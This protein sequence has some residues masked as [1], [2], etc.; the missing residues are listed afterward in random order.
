MD[1]HPLQYQLMIL[2]YLGIACTYVPY[3]LVWPPLTSITAWHRC[4]IDWHTL[5][6]LDTVRLAHST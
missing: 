3:H 6:Q 5:E 2:T 1:G 4:L